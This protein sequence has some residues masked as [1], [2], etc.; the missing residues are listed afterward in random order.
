MKKIPFLETR[1]KFGR[2]PHSVGFGSVYTMRA[3][4]GG[5]SGYRSGWFSAKVVV[6]EL[7]FLARRR[8]VCGDIGSGWF[9]AKMVVPDL[10]KWSKFGDFCHSAP[11]FSFFACVQGAGPL[12]H[13]RLRTVV[14]I[15]EAA[16]GRPYGCV[17]VSN[18]SM[19]WIALVCVYSYRVRHMGQRGATTA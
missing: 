1:S 11:V 14:F 8:G 12:H 16:H 17:Q 5:K 3:F 7:P 10:Q 6:S 2:F 9:P 4:F 18:S 13:A 19:W 15:L